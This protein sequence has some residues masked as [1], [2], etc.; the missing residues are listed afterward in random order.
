VPLIDDVITN[1][2][3]SSQSIFNLFSEIESY[4]QLCCYFDYFT[5]IILVEEDFQ[6]STFHQDF[7]TNLTNLLNKDK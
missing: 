2:N 4:L 6:E 5:P 3:T 7:H 1:K